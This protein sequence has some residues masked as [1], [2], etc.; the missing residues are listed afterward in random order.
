MSPAL[1]YYVYYR[2]RHGEIDRAHAAVRAFQAAWCAEESGRDARV[3]RREGEADAAGQPLSPTWMEIYRGARASPAWPR[4]A[5]EAALLAGPA[6]GE[7]W[8][9]GTRHLEVFRAG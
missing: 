9:D 5:L 3:L 6:D 8:L 1:E 2:V 7:A 4:E